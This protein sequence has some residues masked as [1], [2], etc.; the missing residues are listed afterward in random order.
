MAEELR[1][2]LRTGLYALVISIVY[3]FLSYEV[4]GTLLLVFLVVGSAI[5]VVSMIVTVKGARYFS[6]DAPLGW[7]GRVVVG[8]VG[9]DRP[10]RPGPQPLELEEDPLPEASIWPICAAGAAVL[11]AMGL[12]FGA[13]FWIPGV[14][15]GCTVV[16]GWATQLR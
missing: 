2:F 15:L 3:W 11:V 14:A 16:G 9:F 7:I 12:I 10:H 1:F 8:L 6:V 13:W 4:A 5:F